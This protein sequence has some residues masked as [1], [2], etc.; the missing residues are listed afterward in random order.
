MVDCGDVPVTPYDNAVA[1]E[2]IEAAY[3]T[4]LGRG[5]ATEWAKEQGRTSGLARDGR[6]R[7]RIV[8]LGGDHSVVYPILKSLNKVYGEI[9]VIHFDA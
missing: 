8:G 3:D 5:V 7:P 1:M 9:A 6:E 4:L 2:Q